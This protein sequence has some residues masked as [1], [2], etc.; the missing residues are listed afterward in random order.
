[1][2][3]LI[4]RVVIAWK[5]DRQGE[6]GTVERVD[7]PYYCFV[8]WGDGEVTHYWTAWLT[9]PELCKGRLGR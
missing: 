4:G 2:G 3:G 8:R 5:G 6:R 1:V 9:R 7:T